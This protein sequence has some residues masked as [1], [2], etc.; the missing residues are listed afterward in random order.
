MQ[1]Q[2]A[3]SQQNRP[4]LG[5]ASVVCGC[6]LAHLSASTCVLLVSSAFYASAEIESGVLVCTIEGMIER[7]AAKSPVADGGKPLET[8]CRS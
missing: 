7:W 1:T 8:T 5:L 4:A 3:A 6:S 2:C